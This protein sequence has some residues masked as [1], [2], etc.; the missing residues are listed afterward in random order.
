[1]TTNELE[2][3]NKI[4]ELEAKATMLQITSDA[5]KEYLSLLKFFEVT[6]YI[7]YTEILTKHEENEI[8][9]I[10]EA[11][12][13]CLSIVHKLRTNYKEVRDYIK[14][15]EIKE[16]QDYREYHQTIGSLKYKLKCIEKDNNNKKLL[17]MM[18]V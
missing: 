18:T 16:V 15:S 7:K 2:I 5:V 13:D 3:K 1:M 8:V 17:K 14:L 6:S 12:N 9:L 4:D 10:D 11:Y